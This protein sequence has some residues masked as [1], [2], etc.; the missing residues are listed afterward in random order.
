MVN[1]KKA[2]GLQPVGLWFPFHYSPLALHLE[3]KFHSEADAL[4]P[5]IRALKERGRASLAGGRGHQAGVG[6]LADVYYPVDLIAGSN[7]T[8]PVKERIADQQ[9]QVV[10][11]PEAEDQIRF[12][13]HGEAIAA[14]AANI[15]WQS[16]QAAVEKARGPGGSR[17]QLVPLDIDDLMRVAQGYLA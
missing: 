14:E 1:K 11:D 13:H 3:R 5:E 15:A 8:A 17:D 16:Q 12:R 7:D 4:G 9:L 6:D 2:H 10:R